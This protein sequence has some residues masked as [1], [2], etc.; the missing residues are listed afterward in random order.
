[1]LESKS[2]KNDECTG[3]GVREPEDTEENGDTCGIAKG[4]ETN[5]QFDEGLTKPRPYVNQIERDKW[6]FAVSKDKTMA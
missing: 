6:Q 5:K 1:M 3:D 2:G 4:P